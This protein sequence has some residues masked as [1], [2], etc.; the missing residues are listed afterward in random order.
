MAHTHLVNIFYCYSCTVTK[1]SQKRFKEDWTNI[2]RVDLFNDY[3]LS[4]AVCY[5]NFISSLDFLKEHLQ[6]YVLSRYSDLLFTKI[7]RAYTFSTK[8]LECKV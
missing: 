2:L 5:Y 8:F 3:E 6:E 1:F 7:L 4:Y